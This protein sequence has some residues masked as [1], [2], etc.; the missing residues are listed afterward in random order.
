VELAAKA[1]VQIV[2]SAINA[3]SEFMEG[4][5]VYMVN[6]RVWLVSDVRDVLMGSC[7]KKLLP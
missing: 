3:V 1:L 6:C 2:L 7:F 5:V 4:V